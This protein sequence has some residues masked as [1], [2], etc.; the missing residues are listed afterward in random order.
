MWES[1]IPMSRNDGETL[2]QAQGRLWGIPSSMFP[3]SNSNSQFFSAGRKSN[4]AEFM[5]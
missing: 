5:Q 1:Q 2:R 4:A 3:F